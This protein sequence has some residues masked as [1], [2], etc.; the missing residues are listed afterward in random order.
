MAISKRA[1]RKRARKASRKSNR[2]T[3]RVNEAIDKCCKFCQ[4]KFNKTTVIPKDLVHCQVVAPKSCICIA[5]FNNQ[6]TT[7][8]QKMC[9]CTIYFCMNDYPVNEHHLFC[10]LCEQEFSDNTRLGQLCYSFRTSSKCVHN[11]TNT[12]KPC[13]TE[14]LQW[15]GCDHSVCMAC[16]DARRQA[17]IYNATVCPLCFPDLA[18]GQPPPDGYRGLRDQYLVGNVNAPVAVLDSDDEDI[19]GSPQYSPPPSSDSED[20]ILFQDPFERQN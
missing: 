6:I 11:N 10:P 14:K 13:C 2:T 20:D 7:S 3:N 19:P 1:E 4:L 18:L 8:N 15:V 12:T 9:G 16:V 17:R 5:C